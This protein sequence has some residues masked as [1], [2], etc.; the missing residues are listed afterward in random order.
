MRLGLGS[1]ILASSVLTFAFAAASADAADIAAGAK[2]FK[3]CQQCHR[4]GVGATNFYGPV[5]NGVNGRPAGTYPHYKYSKALENSKIVWNYDTLSKYL[6]EPQHA[7]PGV[8]MTFKGLKDQTDVDNVI[9][10]I[11]Q[12]RSDGGKN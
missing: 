8:A 6:K 7:V 12:F 9:A 11:S 1:F 3:Q 4:I 5:L 2:V 10:Y